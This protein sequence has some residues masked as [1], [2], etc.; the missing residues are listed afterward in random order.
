MRTNEQ[1]RD[2]RGASGVEYGLLISGIFLAITGAVYGFGGAFKGLSEENCD[3]VVGVIKNN[4]RC[5]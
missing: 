5:R 4:E 1:Q 3:G 2:E